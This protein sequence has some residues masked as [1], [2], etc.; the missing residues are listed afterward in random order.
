MPYP[1]MLAAPSSVA[2]LCD[3]GAWPA[4]AAQRDAFFA[5]RCQ[6][7]DAWGADQAQA[8]VVPLDA[9]NGTVRGWR[10]EP[11][12]FE[13][14]AEAGRHEGLQNRAVSR[15]QNRPTGVPRP[16]LVDEGSDP[17]L[18]LAPL[19]PVRRPPAPPPP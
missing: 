17:S 15:H 16:L 8:A 14:Q 9:N 1:S 4:G 5:E 18:P 11:Q 3:H 13:G 19:P 12:L 10:V 2:R 7:L 6:V